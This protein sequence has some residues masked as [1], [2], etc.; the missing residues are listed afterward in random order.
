MR[1]IV[2]LPIRNW[3]RPWRTPPPGV[4]WLRVVMNRDIEQFIGSLNCRELD[5]VEISGTALA[6]RCDFRSYRSVHFPDYDVCEAPVA[7]EAYDLVVAEQVFEH[8][9]RPARAAANVFRTLRPGGVFVIST[10]FLLRVHDAPIDLYRWTELGMRQLLEDA[11]FEVM[12]TASW[13]NLDCLAA[14]MVPR[15]TWTTYDPRRHSLHNDP[16]FPIVVWAF[17]RKLGRD[18]HATMSTPEHPAHVAE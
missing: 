14:E 9:V 13:G 17:A 8:I 4:Q 6:G 10:P 1:V 12:K 18:A 7:E 5:V 16:Q 2:P 11:G 3:I 15:L